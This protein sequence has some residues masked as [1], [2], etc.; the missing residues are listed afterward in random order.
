MHYMSVYL[1]FFFPLSRFGH[2]E[3]PKEMECATPQEWGTLGASE[4]EK[5]RSSSLASPV[6]SGE[7]RATEL[8]RDEF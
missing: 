4:L 5:A 8:L 3:V 7:Q 2:M 1:L 6:L